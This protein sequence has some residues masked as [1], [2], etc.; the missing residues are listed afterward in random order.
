MRPAA[1]SARA[2]LVLL[3]VLATPLCAAAA[4]RASSLEV[5]AE[6]A[7]TC[8]LSGSWPDAGVAGPPAAGGATIAL[9]CTK[10]V[11][12]VV[13][14]QRSGGSAMILRANGATAPAREAIDRRPPTARSGA[15]GSVNEPLITTIQF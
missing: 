9:T 6:I 11:I 15:T 4:T 2:A 14:S 5:S 8:R 10:G 7:P 3:G 12:A 1:R 13:A